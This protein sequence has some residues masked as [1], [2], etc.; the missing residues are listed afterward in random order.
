MLVGDGSEDGHGSGDFDGDFGG[1]NGGDEFDDNIEN[2]AFGS[3][4]YSHDGKGC[5]NNN[6]GVNYLVTRF[7]YFPTRFSS[8]HK[9]LVSIKAFTRFIFM[10]TRFL[11]M[12]ARYA[13][14]VYEFYFTSTVDFVI[15]FYA[16]NFKQIY[17]FELHICLLQKLLG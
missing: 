12:L 11:T 8:K 16:Y 10:L 5:C 6:K 2:A 4:A 17:A 13:E 14:L 3:H 1:E 7:H 15:Y 9:Y